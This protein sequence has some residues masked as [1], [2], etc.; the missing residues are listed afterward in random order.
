M[1]GGT[2][3]RE[4]IRPVFLELSAVLGVD[5]PR[6]VKFEGMVCFFPDDTQK[7]PA[8]MGFLFE[9]CENGS[10][11]ENLH[12]KKTLPAISE[13]LRLAL[14]VA[15]GM[16]HL[17]D[18]NIIH[19]DLNSNNV[20]LTKD[21]GAKICDFGCAR[22]IGPQ[23]H[24]TPTTISG[25]P[26]YMSPEQLTGADRLTVLSDV[27]AMGVLTWELLSLQSPWKDTVSNVNDTDILSD[28]VIRQR[29]R[30][31]LAAWERGAPEPV[32]AELAALLDRSFAL[33]PEQRP[34]MRDVVAT[35]RA[36][37]AR[38]RVKAACAFARPL[39]TGGGPGRSARR[40]RFGLRALS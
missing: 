23:G 11:Y 39:S 40:A 3:L 15:E 8:E 20:V 10:L 1:Q 6:I 22:R 19:R 38:L 5:H 32:R 30:L 35:L 4:A 21:F 26:S 29:R 25:S 12:K 16:E 36:V 14:E 24:I 27:W 13:R 28:L 9:Y 7:D 33:V 18:L 17:H 34:A 31:P 37:R 2:K